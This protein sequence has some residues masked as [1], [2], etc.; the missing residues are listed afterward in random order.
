MEHL[1]HPPSSCFRGR[2]HRHVFPS[3]RP[4]KHDTHS[5]LITRRAG[6]HAFGTPKA[7]ELT[8]ENTH[9]PKRS[10]QHTC[11]PRS[12]QRSTFPASRLLLTLIVLGLSSQAIAQSPSARPPYFVGAWYFTAW[13][14]ANDDVH[15][16]ASKKVYGRYDPWGGV[17][18]EVLGDDRWNL[19]SDYSGREPL[20]GFYDLMD[21]EIMEDHIR[22]AA[23]RGLSYFAFYWYWDADHNRE[24]GLSTP[25]HRYVSAKSKNLMRFLLAPITVGKKPM[26]LSMWQNSVVPILVDRYLGDPAYLRATDGRPFIVDFKIGLEQEAD[27]RAAIL[28]LRQAVRTRLGRDPIVLEVVQQHATWRD[29]VFQRRHV[30]P[31]GFAGFQ[32][33]PLRPAEPYAESVARSV[34]TI[35][36]QNQPFHIPC[37]STG[38]DARPWFKVGWGFRDDGPF[39]RPYNTGITPELFENDLRTMRQYIDQHPTQTDRM[40]T[41]Y[42]WNEWG[43]GGI[44]EPSAK[45]GY[46]YLDMVGN[47]FGLPRRTAEPQLSPHRASFI[48]Q[49]A[50]PAM[51]P[52]QTADVDVTLMNRGTTTWDEHSA[53]SFAY[54]NDSSS[55]VRPSPWGLDRVALSPGERVAPGQSKS[56]RFSVHAPGAP[57]QADFEWRMADEAG[58]GFGD[59]TPHLSVEIS[60]SVGRA[61]QPP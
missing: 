2:L 9:S 16:K 31:D 18:D 54:Y 21:P 32:F 30:G 27:H 41:V 55:R 14:N 49:H 10:K 50:P 53:L 22:M 1:I 48:S 7:R 43:E 12:R 5:L 35:Q 58:R 37:A 40:L 47:V 11:D 38:F 44:I 26:T 61:R 36:S 33:P 3:R 56:F 17:R 29:L 46:R 25:L 4:R 13:S 52:N 51:A 19:H 59:F 34:W 8:D 20:L 45:A 42:A 24:S 28:I 6:C 23:S 15:P 39:Q 60:P 57:G